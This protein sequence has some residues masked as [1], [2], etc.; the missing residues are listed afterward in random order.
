MGANRAGVPTDIPVPPPA[1]R[2]TPPASREPVGASSL[3]PKPKAV[4]GSRSFLP[5]QL[6]MRS[7]LFSLLL[8][9]LVRLPAAEY[10]KMGEDIY[11]PHADAAQDVTRALAQA[12]VENKH[13]LLDFGANW[14]IWCHRLHTL[15]TSDA[16]I[17][18]QLADNYVVVMIDANSRH[19]KAR[20]VETDQKYGHPIANGL[21]VLVVLDASGEILTTQETGALEEGPAHDPA[22]VTAFLTKWAPPR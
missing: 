3:A 12:A 11:D 10:P 19:G 4:Q 14:C 18:Q 16:A 22:K 5:I 8:L 7:L 15:F 13:V 6:P 20:N 17:A 2:I 9:S 21:P 1:G